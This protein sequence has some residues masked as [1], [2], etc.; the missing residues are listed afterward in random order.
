MSRGWG[1]REIFSRW[2]ARNRD[3]RLL[4][5]PFL[6]A[7]LSFSSISFYRPN[8]RQTEP[9]EITNFTA[10]MTTFRIPRASCTPF[11]QH[12]FSLR[13]FFFIF[14]YFI[15]FFFCFLSLGIATERFRLAFVRGRVVRDDRHATRCLEPRNG[16]G[17]G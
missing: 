6:Y 4:S 3:R 14:F 10:P 11:S 8:S 5:L 15:L 9:R 7:S 16:R 13:R 12:F 2:F 1:R 17:Q